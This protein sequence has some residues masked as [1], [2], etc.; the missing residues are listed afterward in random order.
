MMG[1]VEFSA[2]EGIRVFISDNRDKF[3]LHHQLLLVIVNIES[4]PKN[5]LVAT[6][7][8]TPS[9]VEIIYITIFCGFW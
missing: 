9:A 3:D 5:N 6:K 4:T 2:T 8:L 7:A 1:M